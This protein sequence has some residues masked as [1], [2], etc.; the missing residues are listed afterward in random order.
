MT[1][2]MTKWLPPEIT[3]NEICS[4][5]DFVHFYL[6]R[7]VSCMNTFINMSIFTNITINLNSSILI[8]PYAKAIVLWS[9]IR[10][11]YFA[12]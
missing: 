2:M 4:Y 12:V 1:I 7:F 10:F 6:A 8:S 11:I 9:N 5:Y 3:K